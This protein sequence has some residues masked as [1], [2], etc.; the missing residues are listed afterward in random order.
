MLESRLGN[1]QW[2]SDCRSKLRQGMRSRNCIDFGGFRI[3]R[4]FDKLIL[5]DGDNNHELPLPCKSEAA[6][7]LEMERIAQAIEAGR[8]LPQIIDVPE[9]RIPVELLDPWIY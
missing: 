3:W 5:T 2:A 1:D 9:S 7:I 4:V 8:N 6:A